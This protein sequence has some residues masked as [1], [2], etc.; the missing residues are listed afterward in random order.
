MQDS[1]VVNHQGEEQPNTCSCH[2]FEDERQH[3]ISAL[4]SVK[5]IHQ[6]TFDGDL[7]EIIDP[8]LKRWASNDGKTLVLPG[9]GVQTSSLCGTVQFAIACPNHDYK[10]GL[11]YHNCH[12]VT[13]PVCYH[14]AVNQQTK[15]IEERLRGLDEAYRLAG[16][17]TGRWKHIVASFNPAKWTEVMIL[18]DNGKSFKKACRKVMKKNAKNG[19]WGGVEIF[20][21]YRKKHDDG[22]ECEDENCKKHHVWV[23]GPHCHYIT[24]GFFA[25]SEDIYQDTGMLFKNIKPG[26]SRD[27]GATAYYLLTHSAVFVESAQIIDSTSHIEIPGTEQTRTQGLGYCYV[28][29]FATNKGAVFTNGTDIQTVPCPKCGTELHRYDYDHT[30]EK[31]DYDQDQGLHQVKLVLRGCYLIHRCSQLSLDGSKRVWFERGPIVSLM[32]SEEDV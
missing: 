32:E 18:K 19:F 17:Q 28:G 22:T 14:W 6:K 26:Q 20:H 3:C 11:R 5:H 29:E 31:P 30:G 4:D 13:C 16:I 8:R 1:E 15:R 12:K 2:T 10:P 23:W 7:L 24:K 21:P 9:Q 25:P 27:V